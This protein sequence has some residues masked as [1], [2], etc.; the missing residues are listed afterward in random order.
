MFSS[1]T[2]YLI[3]SVWVHEKCQF[4]FNSNLF[5]ALPSLP[6][7]APWENSPF[8]EW[9]HLL[10]DHVHLWFSAWFMIASAYHQT[11]DRMWGPFIP[12]SCVLCSGVDMSLLYCHL[13]L[14]SEVLLR[15][16]KDFE[17]EQALLFHFNQEAFIVI[18]FR[19]EI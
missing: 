12:S 14:G 19:W 1:P 13:L 15:L 16:I 11:A 18:F 6:L 7:Q 8:A 4:L 17:S 3:I 2:Q 9:Q 5:L 10:F